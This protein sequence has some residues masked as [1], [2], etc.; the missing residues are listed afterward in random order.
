MRAHA[1]L[2][3][4]ALASLMALAACAA[5]PPRSPDAQVDELIVKCKARQSYAAKRAKRGG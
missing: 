5:E 1:I 4:F 2:N 3:P